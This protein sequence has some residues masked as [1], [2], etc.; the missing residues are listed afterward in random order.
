MDAS[1]KNDLSIVDALEEA[2]QL[3]KKEC[4]VLDHQT[5]TASSEILIT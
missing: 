4:K 2:I 5:G 3:D 1:D